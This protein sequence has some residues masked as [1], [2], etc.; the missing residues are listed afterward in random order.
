MLQFFSYNISLIYDLIIFRFFAS[1]FLVQSSYSPPSREGQ[2]EGSF[3]F[4]LRGI[5]VTPRGCK[6]LCS[7]AAL[8]LPPQISIQSYEKKT[9]P[10][11][12]TANISRFTACK[13]YLQVALIVTC[14]F[15]AHV[16]LLICCK[17]QHVESFM[18]KMHIS[19]NFSCNPHTSFCISKFV[20]HFSD[21]SGSLPPSPSHPSLLS[22]SLQSLR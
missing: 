17:Y 2:R 21:L 14:A 13:Y 6:F 5:F 8:C 19:Q 7:K 11:N 20:I 15:F 3:Y 10:P 9:N 22:C 4:P 18:Q 12:I 16:G 1:S